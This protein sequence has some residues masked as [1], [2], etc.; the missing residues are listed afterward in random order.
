MNVESHISRNDVIDS[1]VFLLCVIISMRDGGEG[2]AGG[3]GRGRGNLT[4][5]LQFSWARDVRFIARAP[6]CAI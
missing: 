1:S 6:F 3:R 4:H 5:L 2:M